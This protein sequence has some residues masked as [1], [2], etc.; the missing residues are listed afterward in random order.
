M[1]VFLDSSP[2]HSRFLS[3]DLVASKHPWAEHLIGQEKLGGSLWGAQR[4]QCPHP[5]PSSASLSALL[6]PEPGRGNSN[7]TLCTDP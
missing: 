2:R 3:R 1:A 4:N 7:P 5:R 6:T